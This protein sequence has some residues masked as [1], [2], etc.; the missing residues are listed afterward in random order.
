MTPEV[1][2]LLNDSVNAI[3][4]SPEVVAQ[5]RDTFRVEP[6]PVSVE[7]FRKLLQDE[8][9]KWKETGKRVKLDTR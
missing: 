7:A 3:L 9:A 1:I 8:L 6:K 5:M 4:H 2:R